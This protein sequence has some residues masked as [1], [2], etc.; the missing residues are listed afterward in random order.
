MSIR[1]QLAKKAFNYF[2]RTCLYKGA[3]LGQPNYEGKKMT[4]EEYTLERFE[5]SPMGTFG[6]MRHSGQLLCV[7][8]EDPW[9]DNANGISCIPEGRY[10]VKKYSSPKYPDVWEVESVPGRTYILIHA[11]NTTD[12]TRGCILV[13]STFGHLKG[14]PAV[15]NS[16]TTL[17]KLRQ[18]LPDEFYLTI[19]S[20]I[21]KKM[22]V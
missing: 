19:V 8:C 2:L 18:V 12:D 17:N 15:L 20:V 5:T 11:G 21:D 9:N 13:G 1:Y 6:E 22:K 7:T 10:L 4:P 3:R 14:R 16:K